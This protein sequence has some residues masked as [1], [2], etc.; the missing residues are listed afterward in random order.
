MFQRCLP[1][2]VFNFSQTLPL[3]NIA[4]H[5]KVFLCNP[6]AAQPIPIKILGS[7]K[8]N[9]KNN[10]KRTSQICINQP[11]KHIVF[12]SCSDPSN[13][14]VKE[15]YVQ[16]RR[17]ILQFKNN[18]YCQMM[19]ELWGNNVHWQLKNYKWSL[20]SL[21]ALKSLPRKSPI[22]RYRYISDGPVR[23]CETHGVQRLGSLVCKAAMIC[24]SKEN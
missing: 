15:K 11:H 16:R 20:A 1:P 21:T 2:L 10:N 3:N 13:V 14:A 5:Q 17:E 7:Q 4:P 18:L 6:T 23:G 8:T 19:S 9:K 24:R 12:F 22:R